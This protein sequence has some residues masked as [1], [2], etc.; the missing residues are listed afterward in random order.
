MESLT[1]YRHPLSGHSHRVE[2]FLSLLGLPFRMVDVSF[3]AREHKAPE[4]IAKNPFGQLPVLEHG[5]LV[6]P[7]SMAILVYLAKTYDTTGRWF[8]SEPALAAQVQRWFSVA[9]GQLVEGP[10]RARAVAVFGR[11]VDTTANRELARHL[12]ATLDAHLVAAGRPFFVG[13]RATVADL[14]LYTYVG[15]APEGGVS[16]AP[17]P[18][19]R[20]FVG[21]VEALPGFVPMQATDTAAGRA[22]E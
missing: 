1:L 17:F 8:P 12:F 6:I 21:A 5:A 13:E 3:A 9:A 22:A 15:H 20:G 16:L 19:L 4:F 11:D 18:A 10:A 2:L 7:D 14:A